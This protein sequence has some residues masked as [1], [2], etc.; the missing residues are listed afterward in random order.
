MG[1]AK[2]KRVQVNFDEGVMET[3]E[4]L[5]KDLDSTTAAE[6]IRKAIG[7]LDWAVQQVEDGY[8]V[9]SFKEGMPH[10][11]VVIRVR[12]RAK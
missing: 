5:Q 12:R 7:L 2:K 11:E 3:L 10:K 1:E 8:C 9:G 6:V 4:R